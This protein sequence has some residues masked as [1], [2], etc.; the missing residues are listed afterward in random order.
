MSLPSLSRVRKTLGFRLTLWY[1]GFFILSVVVLL[2][3]AYVLLST[4][5]QHHD[6]QAAQLKLQEYVGAYQQG[7]IEAVERKVAFEKEHIGKILFFVRLASA[8]HKTLSASIPHKW[9]SFDVAQL[10]GRNAGDPSQWITL[11]VKDDEEVLEIISFRFP[12]GTLLQVGLN[13]DPREDVLERFRDTL[14]VILVPLLVMGVGGGAFLAFRAL[15]PVRD[16]TALL[17][18]II[19]TG[20]L[21]ARAP[22]TGTGDELEEL[23]FLFNNMLD[24]IGAL[25]T[26]MR[27]ALDNVAHD[28]RTPMTRLRGMA[29]MA[30]RA[31]AQREVLRDALANCIEEAD[32]IVAMVNTLMDISEAET[33]A[34]KL[35]LQPV[36]VHAL[37]E[38]TVELYRDVAEDKAITL[39]T[40][41]PEEL[42]I[43]A[44]CARMQQ[45]LVNLLDNAIKY[46]PPGGRVEI[47]AA[48][49]T[50]QVVITVADTGIGITPEDLP[51]IWERLYRSDTSRSQ[52]GMGL[53]LSLVKAIV[54]AHQGT[55]EVS[56]T[57]GAGS[58]FLLALPLCSPAAR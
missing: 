51:K 3:A 37:I 54:Q 32:R 58:R 39:S 41:A 47:V 11:P 9:A 42:S 21:E 46:T 6:R 53:G 29:E 27:H 55:V 31:D 52:R 30:L 2:G 22:G 25:I 33:G 4:S 26:G 48:L 28:L 40:F 5:L 23:S 38:R 34:M 50:Q 7:G 36:N 24:R 14:A 49:H 57:P 15:R 44:D 17:R 19:T 1:F 16:L 45:V 35:E 10:E 13:T 18:S 8:D 56:S 43:T 12:D 20:K